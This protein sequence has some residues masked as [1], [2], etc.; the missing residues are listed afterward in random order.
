MADTGYARAIFSAGRDVWARALSEAAVVAGISLLP[1]LL[2]AFRET[3]P[4]GTQVAPAFAK[5]FLSGQLLFYAVG[6]I[7]TVVWQSNKDFP[8]FFPLRI[9]INL[10]CLVELVIC[11]FLI[12]FDPTLVATDKSVVAGY[13]ITLFVVAVAFYILMVVIG[14]VHVNVG[15][16][17]AKDDAALQQGVNQSRGIE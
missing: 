11:S 15:Q 9:V 4:D 17:L 14:E 5:A 10:V 16:S 6:L 13:S 1:L 2:A 3:L 12:G 8:R 7:A